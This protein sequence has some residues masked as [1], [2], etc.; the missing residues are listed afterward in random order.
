MTKCASCRVRNLSCDALPIC[1]ECTKS[2]RE[3]SRLNVRFKHLV[4]PSKEHNRADYSKYEF[5]FSGEQT[6]VDI[7]GKTE[8]VDSTIKGTVDTPLI[9]GL[10]DRNIDTAERYS[11]PRLDSIEPPSPA[12]A[13]ASTS[14]A[15]AIQIPIPDRPPDYLA[16]TEQGI[17]RH[18][19]GFRPSSDFLR[20]TLWRSFSVCGKCTYQ[21]QGSLSG[22]IITST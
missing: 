17:S 4:C 9:D 19:D 5:F 7:E 3:C 6:W 8:F 22:E 18:G 11:E 14:H 12:W 15:P 20:Q 1:N 13:D 16:A 2:G 10:E 21:H